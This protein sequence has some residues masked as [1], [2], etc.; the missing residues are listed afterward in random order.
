MR[1]RLLNTCYVPGVLLGTLIPRAACEL[2]DVIPARQMRKA[3]L[4]GHGTCTRQS[5]RAS[6]LSPLILTGEFSS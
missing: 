2:S 4:R 6:S 3:G 1:P 5:L